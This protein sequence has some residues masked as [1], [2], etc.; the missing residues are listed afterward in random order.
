MITEYHRPETV[1]EALS[2]LARPGIETR[3][4]GGGLTLNQPSRE[5]FAVVDIQKLALNMLEKRAN[6]IHIGAAVTLQ[7]LIS[8]G[9]IPAVIQDCIVKETGY[10][11]RQV[12]TTAGTVI[13]ADGRSPFTAVMMA[14]DPVVEFLRDGEKPQEVQLG[15]FMP[16]RA[17][18]IRERLISKLTFNSQVRVAYEQVARTPVD[19][20]IVLA[21]VGQWPSNRTRVIIGGYG[22]HPRMVLDGQ[23]SDGAAAAASDSYR[24][25]EDEWASAAYRSDTAGILV[26]R[27]LEKLERMQKRIEP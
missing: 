10:N 6:T 26:E 1:E 8:S 22:D 3:V 16:L 13:S 19:R 27:C 20:P 24:E 14:F 12:A 5:E 25:A 11:R 23:G 18:M 7:A 2:L 9:F 17:E 4:L 21:A 15:D